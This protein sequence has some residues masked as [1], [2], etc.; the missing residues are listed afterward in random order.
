MTQNIFPLLPKALNRVV[1]V[2]YF[3]IWNKEE[4]III[5]SVIS[6]HMG[7]VYIEELYILS[8]IIS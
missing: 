3:Q 7:P 8:E 2:Y 6:S 4:Y 1:I 5:I